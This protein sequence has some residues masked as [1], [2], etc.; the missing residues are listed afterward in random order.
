MTISQICSNLNI[1][2][3]PVT[4]D[5]ATPGVNDWQCVSVQLQF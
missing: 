5:A 2:S 3:T 4:A 1:C